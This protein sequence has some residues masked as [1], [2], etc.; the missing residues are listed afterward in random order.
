M[1]KPPPPVN[2][3]YSQTNS[4]FCQAAERFQPFGYPANR[5]LLH[6]FTLVQRHHHPLFFSSSFSLSSVPLITHHRYRPTNLPTTGQRE[7]SNF[8]TRQR[9]RGMM[10]FFLWGSSYRCIN[11]HTYMLHPTSKPTLVL[12]M[13]EENNAQTPPTIRLL[14]ILTS[15]S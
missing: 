7:A 13:I 5:R 2:G 14:G 3:F 1:E 8:P 4:T 11:L 9:G 6:F 15:S 12:N 10:K